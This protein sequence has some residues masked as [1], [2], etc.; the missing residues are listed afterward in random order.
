MFSRSISA[1]IALTATLAATFSPL[2]LTA[3]ADATTV[4][5][6]TAPSI[7]KISKDVYKLNDITINKKTREIKITALAEVTAEMLVEYLL[8]N[9]DGKIHESL[10]IT[11]TLPSHLNIAFKLL[12][13]KESKHLLH[14]VN[15]NYQPQPGYEKSTPEQKKK[16]KFNITINWDDNGK[17]KSFP[18][19]KLIKNASS[20]KP[21]PSG[22][23]VYHGSFMHQ[24]KFAADLNH[25]LFALLTDRGAL[26]NYA[27]PGREDD[28]LWLPQEKNMPAKGT[29]VTITFSPHQPQAAQ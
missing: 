27:G 22:P 1:T 11:D 28:T 3:Q 26:G 17:T 25:D 14:P 2:M 21:L 6:K 20:L 24:G 18:I 5:K 10:F 13:F 29:K 23:W 4:E 16:S 7:V 8:V 15:K 12:G 19:H 9:P